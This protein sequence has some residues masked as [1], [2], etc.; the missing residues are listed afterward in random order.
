M[1]RTIIGLWIV[2]CMG[3]ILI[4]YL[5]GRNIEGYSSLKNAMSAV[6]AKVNGG[7]SMVYRIWL[8]LFGLI[9]VFIFY[10]L[11]NVYHQRMYQITICVVIFYAIFGC[12]I[13]GIF[14]SG[15][16]KEMVTIGEK[17]H[18]G[19]SVFGF[20]ALMLI[21]LL[22][23]PLLYQ[24]NL[25][26]QGRLSYVFFL[27]SLIFFILQIV[28][29]REQFVGTFLGNTGLWQRFYLSIHYIYI[30]FILICVLPKDLKIDV[31]IK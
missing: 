29:E 19:A 14:P 24:L 7:I 16:T 3:E 20:F 26:I 28:S 6:G 31:F 18:G 12:I 17:I 27:V 9:A 10:S 1:K 8:I 30:T 21:P 25:I 23:R 22:M 2:L 15:I 13:C 11:R 5:L 4:P